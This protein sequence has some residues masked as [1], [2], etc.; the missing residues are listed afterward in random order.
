[1]TCKLESLTADIT[2]RPINDI[3]PDDEPIKTNG[4]HRESI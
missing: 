1:M 3:V 2:V 4:A